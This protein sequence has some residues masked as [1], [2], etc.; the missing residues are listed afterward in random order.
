[1]QSFVF[2]FWPEKYFIFTRFGGS[3][4]NWT[5]TK[6]T[7]SGAGVCKDL[8][9]QKNVCER[10]REARTRAVIRSCGEKPRQL[11]EVRLFENESDPQATKQYFKSV[12]RF[13]GCI[14]AKKSSDLSEFGFKMLAEKSC[15]PSSK[16]F[17][18][19]R[20][21]GDEISLVTFIVCHL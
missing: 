15:L 2:Q 10:G 3:L 6:H 14:Q 18:K 20:W 5:H 1:M 17:E 19:T 12:L 9:N 13:S 21:S 16:H 8:S 7:S 11:H 4:Q